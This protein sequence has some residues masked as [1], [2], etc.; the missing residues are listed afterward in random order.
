MPDFLNSPPITKTQTYKKIKSWVYGSSCFLEFDEVL[1]S[2]IFEEGIAQGGMN[3]GQHVVCHRR[4]DN[5][6]Q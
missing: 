4:K 5:D 3:I 2:W 6:N 1:V